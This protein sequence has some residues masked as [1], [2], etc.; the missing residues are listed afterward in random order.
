MSL[1][2][3]RWDTRGGS[4]AF[5]TTALPRV[6]RRRHR[7]ARSTTGSLRL[8]ELRLNDVVAAADLLLLLQRAVLLLSARLRRP[9]SAAQRRARGDGPHHSRGH[10]G[11]RARVRHAL[12]RRIVQVALGA[13]ARSLHR[14]HLFPSDLGRPRSISAPFA[15]NAPRARSRAASSR[16]VRATSNVPRAGAGLL[17]DA[18]AAAIWR[19][20]ALPISALREAGYR[21][22]ARHRLSPRRRGLGRPRRGPTCRR[23]LIEPGDVR[24]PHRLDRPSFPVRRAS[25]ISATHARA[26]SRSTD[27][28]AAVT[29]DDGYRD[30]YEH[31]VPVLKRK[32]IPAAVFVVTDLV[33]RRAGRCTT[34][35]TTCSTRR[36]RAGSDP[37]SGL[38]RVCADCG[39]SRH[40]HSRHAGG[41][42]QLRTA[43]YRRSCRS[44]RRPMRT[45]LMAVLDAQRRQRRRRR[46]AD[47]DVADAR[48]HAARRVHDRLAHANARLAARRRR[49]SAASRSLAGSKQRARTP[50]WRAGR[51]FRLSGRTVHAARRRSRRRAPATASR[52]TAC[53]HH[54][55][56]HP[57]L[58]IQR[59]LLWEGSSIDADGHFSSAILNCQTHGLWPPARRCERVHAA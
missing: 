55:R 11:R 30:V 47:A 39:R 41:Q 2:N 10:R 29:F 31:A 32:G 40:G 35:S 52:Y 16:G 14:I 46:S 56:G 6:P 18:F 12:R 9:L 48:R 36:S 15:P 53:D 22:A 51:A 21:R 50:P 54:D 19:T 3:R 33:G 43:R 17:K 58:T 37:W 38:T 34:T 44:C 1:H 26:A 28:V 45:A 27:P 42:P 23:M 49:T 20:R 4:T 7:S 59:L 25:T 8:Y 24:A 13:P 57:A 5:P